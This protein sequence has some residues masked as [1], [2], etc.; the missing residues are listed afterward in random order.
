MALGY[1]VP[2][3]GQFEKASSVQLRNTMRTDA[4]EDVRKACWEVG[5]ISVILRSF[6]EHAR[7]VVHAMYD[8]GMYNHS[9][10]CLS[11]YAMQWMNQIA[12]NVMQS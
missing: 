7:L 5:L 3:K 12:Y 11:L 10:T 8:S 2:G 6:T 1:T 4:S 9:H